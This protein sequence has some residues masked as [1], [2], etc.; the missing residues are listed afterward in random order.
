MDI[1][2][3]TRGVWV[4]REGLGKADVPRAGQGFGTRRPS[5][6]VTRAQAWVNAGSVPPL[7]THRAWESPVHTGLFEQ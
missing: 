4:G 3:P 2:D 1:K 7:H 5:L 6:A